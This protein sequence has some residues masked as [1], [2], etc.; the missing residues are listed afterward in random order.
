MKVSMQPLYERL[1]GAGSHND[2]IKSKYSTWRSI[3]AKSKDLSKS[4]VLVAKVIYAALKTL[5]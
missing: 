4:R 5:R 3:M 1:S 2:L